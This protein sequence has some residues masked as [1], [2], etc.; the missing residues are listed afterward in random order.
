[1][2][3]RFPARCQR[4]KFRGQ[5]L[6]LWLWSNDKYLIFILVELK[7]VL[8]HPSINVYNTLLKIIN[9]A[10]VIRRWTVVEKGNFHIW[11]WGSE[12]NLIAC[13]DLQLNPCW[14]NWMRSHWKACALSANAL[15]RTSTCELCLLESNHDTT[16][17]NYHQE[18]FF[19]LIPIR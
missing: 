3:P 11:I 1:M 5:Y 15:Q 18:C 17:L 12:Q 9:G 13:S 2:T 7:E 14:R 8:N 4:L 10:C 6:S 16:S 19:L